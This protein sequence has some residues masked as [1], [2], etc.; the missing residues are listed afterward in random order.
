MILLLVLIVFL[1][2]IWLEVPPLVRQKMWRELIVFSL[3][4][5]IGMALSIPQVLGIPVP[6]PNGPIELIFQ[7]FADWMKK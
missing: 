2:I 7:P 5:L 4:M 3:F 6:S 1:A